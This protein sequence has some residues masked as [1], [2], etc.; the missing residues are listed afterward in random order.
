MNAK[1]IAAAL[2]AVVLL[3]GIGVGGTLAWL[4]A[5]T[6][7][8]VNTFTTSNIGVTLEETKNDFQMI[9][10]WTIDKDPKATVTAG[11]E[12]AYLFIKV[13]ENG[14]TT[15]YP[16]GSF[17]EYAIDEKWT[18]LDAT[19]YPGVYY[20]VVDDTT[21]KI[22]QAYSILG[23]GKYIYND[24]EYTWD[25]D[26]VLT[27]PEVTKEM[28]RAISTSTVTNPVELPTLTFTAYASQL[29]KNNT[30]RFT[31]AEAWANLNLPATP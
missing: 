20:M 24:V 11:S 27:K 19:H 3:I 5:Q 14:G 13:V 1:K 25:N 31:P 18:A 23:D 28:M 16:F 10:G 15:Q 29:Y 30:E 17:I 26:E 7:D 2:L 22:G 8:V 6:T 12:E 21:N 4:T 9:P